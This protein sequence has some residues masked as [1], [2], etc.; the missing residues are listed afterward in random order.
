VALVAVGSGWYQAWAVPAYLNAD[1]QAHVG[2][3]L[4]LL[5]GH[6]PTVDQPIPVER[7]GPLLAQRVARTRRRHGEVWVANN[8]PVGYLPFLVPALLARAAG[9]P[10]APLLGLRLTSVALFGA[11]AVMTARLGRRLAGGCE[12]VGL[13]SAALLAILPHTGT[14]A[15]AAYLDSVALLCAVGLLDSLVSVSV[16]GPTR[17]TVAAVSAWCAVSAGIRPMSAALAGAAA[18]F[19]LVVAVTR[20]LLD[21]RSEVSGDPCR[22][23]VLW[24]AAVLSVPAVLLDGWFYLRNLHR[25]GD[26]TGST[27]LNAK[28]GLPTG[29]S[30]ADVLHEHI[31]AEPV[32]TLLNR[33]APQ[34][35]PGPPL[36]LWSATRWAMVIALISTVALV[37]ADQ[38]D[39]RRRRTAPRTSG[40][41]WTGAIGIAAL[42]VALA[43]AHWVSGGMIHPRYLF[44]AL[45]VGTVAVMVP[46][47]RLRL[48]WLGLAVVLG[49]GILQRHESPPM[50]Y[51]R[52]RAGAAAS[53][54]ADP[55]GSLL[56][57]SIGPAVVLIGLLGLCVALT[58]MRP[59]RAD[60]PATA[61]VA[62]RA[63]AAD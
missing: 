51:Y 47:H 56:V 31:W 4:T 18:A 32:R 2:Y 34:I 61:S 33:R 48:W 27:Y 9:S 11:A 6:L 26:V 57:R 1:E 45:V 36:W 20:S 17:R 10:S 22:P 52:N 42:T 28:F 63:A 44:P 62:G 59:S 38:L 13:L 29:R 7:G 3:V 39:A 41:A 35:V 53:A 24:C 15:G 46:L 19:V 37:I 23:P 8:P 25:Y 40:L 21:R 30:V 12:A 50:A 43:A 58:W 60:E 5:D 55:P 14:I 49:A 54:L 16:S